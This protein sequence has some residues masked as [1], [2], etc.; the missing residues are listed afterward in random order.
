MNRAIKGLLRGGLV[1]ALA[2]ALLA[3]A[4]WAMGGAGAAADWKKGWDGSWRW[5]TDTGWNGGGRAE[6]LHLEAFDTLEVDVDLGDVRVTAGEDYG[7]SLSWSGERYTLDFTCEDG[8]L[9]V[10]SH[11]SG[12][13]GPGEQFSGSVEVFVPEGTVLRRVSLDTDLGELT[14]EDL[15]C[16]EL[17]VD[18]DLGS[19]TL[20]RTEAERADLSLSLGD[21]EG[22]ELTVT[23]E[24]TADNDLG[25]MSLSGDL[26]GEIALSCSMGGLSFSTD[27]PRESFGYELKVS[28][29]TLKL[30]GAEQKERAERTGGPNWLE[31]KTD[32]GDLEVSFG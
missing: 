29:G 16:R 3:A 19:V 10:K 1:L 25:S 13:L 21:L 32:M 11:S 20:R 7:V 28:M 12:S 31:A 8:T 18:D 6:D 15:R 14:V 24:L 5:E 23:K 22:E 2:G 17:I 27:A 26:R 4:G 30:D 9:R